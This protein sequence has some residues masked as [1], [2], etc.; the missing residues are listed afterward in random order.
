M[1]TDQILK[2]MGDKTFLDK[3]YQFSYHRCNTSY[4]AEDLCS[5]IIL[6]VIS[7]L[8][9]SERVD[10]FHAYVWTIAKRVYA[11]FC[12]KRH[13]FSL[14]VNL[15]DYALFLAEKEN[16][17][18]RFID[19]TV[20]AEQLRQIFSQIAFL[21][22]TYRDVMVM[23]YIDEFKMKDIAQALHISETTVKQ[24]LF[25]ARNTIRKEV[26]NMNQR[27]LSL[28]PVSL[29]FFGIGNP[30][31][32]DPRTKAERTFSQN[33]IYLCK[34]KPKTAREL[35]D[36]LCVPM[37]Y[38]E[39]ELEIQCHGENGS[40]GMLRRLDNGRYTINT[41]LVDYE[42]YDEANKIYEKHLPEY[43]SILK[44]NLEEDRTE[45]LSFPYL[46]PQQDTRFILWSMITDTVCDLERKINQTISRKHFS[47]ITP[48]ERD[49]STIAIA[50]HDSVPQ[51]LDFYGR[52]GITA[53]A[54]SGY[55]NVFVSNIYGNRIDKHFHCGHNISQD[56]KLLITLKAIGG[57]PIDKL[58]ELE[59]EIA[60]KAI[61]CGYLHKTA[62]GLEPKPI[63][64]E[65]GQKNA[66]RSLSHRL[67]RGTEHIIEKIADE[68]AA[69]MKKHI[70]AHLMN[71][72]Q[73]YTEEIAGIRILSDV[74]D[75]C[76]KENLLTIPEN[77][78]NAEG[79]LIVVEK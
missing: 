42:E 65:S 38:I 71:E 58:T 66:F 31:G 43:C 78:L 61:E 36:E 5:D 52:D 4:E 2:L 77:R 1:K 18:E 40:Y 79:V 53:A 51:R 59:K 72:Y 25:Y 48:V 15:D 14:N 33:L 56:E 41:L 37:L 16:E 27:N 22:K 32:N 68:S 21:S 20:S 47:D 24:R 3:I 54:I 11:D 7:S 46:S 62:N 17:I 29:V 45:L 23:Y 70:P 44:A 60:A 26:T 35:S 9:K 73:I 28:K 57:L 67:N 10:N 49:F 12:K 69:F 39:E 63:V 34:D 19:D 64:I 76:I 6:A 13:Q 30:C 74:I 50:F 75:E 8:F 55:K